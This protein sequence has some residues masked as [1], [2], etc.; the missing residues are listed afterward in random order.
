MNS[1]DLMYFKSGSLKGEV[2]E[3]VEDNLVYLG[4][5]ASPISV[6]HRADGLRDAT[7]RQKIEWLSR[8]I[9]YIRDL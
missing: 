9:R 5:G 8:E 6:L 4:E 2:C 1:G 3:V 7:D